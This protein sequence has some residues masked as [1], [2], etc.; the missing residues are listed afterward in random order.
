MTSDPLCVSWKNIGIFMTS[1]P[2]G[3]S[4]KIIG[5]PYDKRTL[6]GI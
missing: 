4:W 1:G 6:D 5:N 2:F 3:D